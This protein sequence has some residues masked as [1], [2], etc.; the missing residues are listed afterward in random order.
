MISSQE[1]SPHHSCDNLYLSDLV[2]LCYLDMIQT[3]LTVFLL[4]RKVSYFVDQNFTI[5]GMKGFSEYKYQ[6]KLHNLLFRY[7]CF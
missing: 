6:E 1:I 5:D 2:A 3:I 7:P 4:I